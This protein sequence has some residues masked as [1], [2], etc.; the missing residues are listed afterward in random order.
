MYSYNLSG[1]LRCAYAV[2]QVEVRGGDA[3]WDPG[4]EALSSLGVTLSLLMSGSQQVL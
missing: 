3:S 2:S 4:K 1:C